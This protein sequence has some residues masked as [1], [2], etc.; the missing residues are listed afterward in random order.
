[1][2]KGATNAGACG[3]FNANFRWLAETVLGI[4][5]FSQGQFIGQFITQPSSVCIDA[6][7]VGNVCTTPGGYATTKS[8]KFKDHYWAVQGGTNY[9]VCFNHTFGSSSEIIWS[10]LS[11]AATPL[12][13]K[14][15]HASNEIFKLDKALP[16][17][18]HLVMIKENAYGSW[19]AW[20][21]MAAAKIP[22]K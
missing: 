17:G 8:Y 10:K 11:P 19:P 3:S 12:L 20:Q 22:H 21:I 5:G 16:A 4:T 14:T 15:G 7:W 1:M 2:M 6:K 18:D 9:D 13:T